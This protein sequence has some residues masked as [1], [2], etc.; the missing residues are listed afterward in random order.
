[1]KKNTLYFITLII[2]NFSTTAQNVENTAPKYRRSSLYTLMINDDT[3][4]YANVIRES[5]EKGPIPDKFDD[6]RLVNRV[7]PATNSPDEKDNITQF[8][9]NNHVA[10]ELVAKWFNRSEWGGFNMNL[11]QTRGKYDANAL[12]IKKS[13]LTE[14]GINS[15]ADAGEE[16]IKNTFVLIND[17]RYTSK[18]EVAKKTNKGL[19]FASGLMRAAGMGSI[20]NIADVASVG[21]KVMGKGY[22]VKSTAY[23]YR[24]VWDEETAAKFYNTLWAEDNTITT[25]KL[26]AW[27]ETD[28]F[29]LEF[30]GTDNSW[31]DVQ[32]TVFTKKTEEELIEKA[33]IKAVDAVIVK[34]QKNHD[35]FKTKTPLFSGEPI[36]AKIGLKEGLSEQSKFDVLEQVQDESGKTKYVPVGVI[37]VDSSKPIWDNRYGADEENPNNVT[38]KTYFKKVSGKD[39]FPGMLI[40]QKKGK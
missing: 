5:F 24:L 4:P 33:T 14:R 25:E 37:K 8:L 32:S 10:K 12:D 36:T 38:D 13:Q 26:K 39:L 40:V 6:H 2:I 27:E 21:V 9:Q 19:G 34:L 17:Y 16:L 3:R 30:V 29:K 15:L 11:I 23:L 28:I 18:E 31:A 1:M 22:I 20:A 7:I 35:E